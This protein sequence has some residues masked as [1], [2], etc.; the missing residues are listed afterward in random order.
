M[1]ANLKK[2]FS[3]LKKIG[4]N[5]YLLT[6]VIAAL[7]FLFLDPNTIV[8]WY[9]LEMDK[10]KIQKEIAY[11]RNLSEDSQKKMEQLQTDLNSLEKFAR[12]QFLMKRENEDIFLFE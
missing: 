4:T 12:E 6:T 2:V 10:R 8:H 9:N 3:T 7:W 1:N 5:K 11:Y